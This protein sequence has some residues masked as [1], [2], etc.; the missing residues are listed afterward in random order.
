MVMVIVMVVVIV[1]VVV[2]VMAVGMVILVISMVDMMVVEA[3]EMT[4]V[5]EDLDDKGT[6]DSLLTRRMMM[7]M[8][9]YSILLISHM[10]TISKI[11]WTGDDLDEVIEKNENKYLVTFSR[12]TGRYEFA[13]CEFCKGPICDINKM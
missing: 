10:E 12:A 13:S 3:H 9:P 4:I 8:I 2:G 5:D 1:I 7:P 6:E 11:Y